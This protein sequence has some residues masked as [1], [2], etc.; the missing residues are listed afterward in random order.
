M[1]SLIIEQ[2][3][4]ILDE[5]RRRRDRNTGRGLAVLADAP[6]S[7]Q[8]DWLRPLEPEAQAQ[9]V[10]MLLSHARTGLLAA[11]S[12]QNL[13]GVQ[14]FRAKAAAIHEV[15]KQLRLSQDLQNDATEFLRRAERCLGLA[16]RE[17]QKSGTVLNNN[18]N[19]GP[20]SDYV[21]NGKTVRVQDPLPKRKKL[22]PKD[23]FSGGTQTFDI[24]AMTDGIADDVFDQIIAEA[25]AEGNLSRANIARRAR[26]LVNQAEINADDPQAKP[27]KKTAAARKVMEDLLV[28][29]N[30]LVF[31]INETDPAEVDAQLHKDDWQDMWDAT[32][33]IRKFLKLIG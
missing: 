33:K 8:V 17:G 2:D 19:V 32:N 14:E 22:S 12:A 10:T 7:D 31:V 20:R 4:S 18:E 26:A 21:R 16:I 9:G 27:V 30:S 29:L 28:T 13:P 24:Y 1:S 25:K 6:V 3:G 15:S 5:P 11:I 23:F